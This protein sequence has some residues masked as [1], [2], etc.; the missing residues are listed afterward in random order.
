M[1]SSSRTLA[2][3]TQG[4]LKDLLRR[5]TDFVTDLPSRRLQRLSVRLYGAGVEAGQECDGD[6]VRL[7]RHQFTRPNQVVVSE[8]WAKKGAI[9]IVPRHLDGALVSSHFYLYDLRHAEDVAWFDAMCRAERFTR[10]VQ[11]VSQ[12]T[13]GYAA[14]RPNDFLLFP[15]TYPPCEERIAIGVLLN[16]M[17]RVMVDQESILGELSRLKRGIMARSLVGN[18]GRRRA[19][20]TL[21][22]R[23]V[24][25]RVAG[26]VEYI[27]ADWDL[28]PLTSVAK[29]ESGHTPSRGRPEYWGGQH[30]WLSLADSE[31]LK[32]L[33]IRRTLETITDEGLANSSARILPTGTVVL[34]RTAVIGQSAVLGQP[35]ATSQDFVAFICGP[36]VEPRYLCQVF[37]HMRREWDRLKAGSSPTNKTLYYSIFKAIQVLLPPL[38]EQRRI[39]DVGE[40]FDLRIAAERA[41]LD[42]LRKLKRGLADALLSG[43]VRLPPHVIAELAEGAPDVGK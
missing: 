21:P 24:F 19:M 33:V 9:G 22:E 5:N 7:P 4:R 10:W 11:A 17:T 40:A 2:G 30:P 20:K 31:E 35:T 28:V 14:I 8:I 13:T 43:R 3:W 1:T 37:R 12:G 15:L 42:A 29:L 16:V 18:N 25:G 36:K 41:H 27:P 39:A 23:W 26:G 38:D 6:S 32:N 34:S